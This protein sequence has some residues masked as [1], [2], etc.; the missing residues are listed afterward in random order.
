MKD[1]KIKGLSVIVVAL[2]SI[3]IIWYNRGSD[4][5]S[6]QFSQN[7]FRQV[8]LEEYS[9]EN[10]KLQSYVNKGE[11]TV[12][13]YTKGPISLKPADD[14]TTYSVELQYAASDDTTVFKIFAADYISPDNSGGKIFVNKTLNPAESAYRTSFTLDQ[15]VDNLFITIEGNDPYLT[16]GRV[17][18]RSNEAVF[19]DT[20][21]LCCMIFVLAVIMV[22]ALNS[23]FNFSRPAQLN[24]S[25]IPGRNVALRFFVI[26]AIAV[27]V[28]SLPVL[29]SGIILGHDTPFH[30][31]RIEGIARGI[32]SGQFPVRIHGGT[33]NDYGYPNSLFYPEL[34]LYIPAF[35]RLA[36]VSVYTAYKLYFIIVNALTMWLSYIAF[37]KMTSSRY[38]GITLAVFYLLTPYRILCAYWRNAV[39]E[40]SAMTFLPLVI[41]GLYAILFANQKDWYLL[42]IGATGVLQSH[43]LTTEMTAL[44]AA[45]FVLAGVKNLFDKDRRI[46]SLIYAAVFTVMLNIWFLGPMLIMMLQ[47]GLIVFTR[48]ALTS[49]FASGDISNL[50][51]INKIEFSGPYSIGVIILIAI[52]V[53]AVYRV[54]YEDKKE[55]LFKP[56]DILF[57]SSIGFAWSCT[58]LFPWARMEKVPVIG[59]VVSAIQFPTRMLTIVQLT[60]IALLGLVIIIVF[61]KRNHKILVCV[62]T[63]IAAFY[64][65][66]G[67][68]EYT[69]IGDGFET[70]PNKSYYANNIDNQHSVGQAEYLVE[71][72]D[73]GRMI[74]FAPVIESSN[75]SMAV[76][77]YTRYGT[78]MSFSY[79]MDMSQSEENLIILPVTYIPNYVIMVNGE[80][81]YPIKYID[82]GRVAFT[83]PS[84]TGDVTV[85]YTSPLTFRIFE[86]VT[87]I[88]T[89]AFILVIYLNKKQIKLIKK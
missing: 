19:T 45:V 64:T 68:M 82:G 24:D 33:L 37:K 87:V 89:A 75:P 15:T 22:A 61:K 79:S 3:M 54:L 55:T 77:G 58:S 72:N 44:F 80:R 28:A 29:D 69:V 18:I 59:S 71:G 42:T 36:G 74:A 14:E 21:F 7:E 62:I 50:F 9:A 43:I 66:L 56:A 32:E 52:A 25:E 81:V 48:D 12:H 85:K 31:N 67:F 38:I 53:Y 76:S 65:S 83:P 5:F 51:A 47:L 86:A 26:S 40:F 34:L 23:K 30:M 63:M 11:D 2:I 57:W 1:K 73:L 4:I 60:G 10:T 8:Y 13:C 39:G 88:S 16:I 27:F 35:M 78:K 6:V 20:Y 49:Q 41:Y 84:E 46:L 17:N 70:I